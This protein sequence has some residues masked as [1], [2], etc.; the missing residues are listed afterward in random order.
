MG[1]AHS[2][3]LSRRTLLTLVC[4]VLGLHL[5]VLAEVASAADCSK[6]DY[7]AKRNCERTN[8]LIDKAMKKNPPKVFK[9]YTPT[10]SVQDQGKSQ[11]SSVAATATTARYSN[12]AM[13]LSLD[14]PKEWIGSNSN[15]LE[16]VPGSTAG[17]PDSG[18]YIVQFLGSKNDLGERS[19]T[20]MQIEMNL[21][22]NDATL[23]DLDTDFLKIFNWD[24]RK[25]TLGTYTYYLPNMSA[26]TQSS[27]TVNSYVGKQYSFTSESNNIKFA[28][29]L[30]SV[31]VGNR[32][33]QFYAISDQK[34]KNEG[35]QALE[36]ILESVVFR[37]P[38]FTK[39]VLEKAKS[40]TSAPPTL[41][42][43]YK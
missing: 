40:S 23:D 30:V 14:H 11:K 5:L 20:G 13:G 36:K 9:N 42:L 2:A 18:R 19:F 26:V 6:L 28:F 25:N 32:I 22:E 12:D 35:L 24:V 29:T 39:S 21:L 10:K 34:Y 7:S 15:K 17:K 8:A 38:K 43:R 33:Y 37:E 4:M 27:R 1:S 31:P 16:M 3:P 41:K